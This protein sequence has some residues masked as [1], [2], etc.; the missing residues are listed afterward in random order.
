ME[1][2]RCT[3]ASPIPVFVKIFLYT[4][5][6]LSCEITYLRMACGYIHDRTQG[7]EM[8]I[9][10]QIRTMKIHWVRRP[11][12]ANVSVIG[13]HHRSNALSDWLQWLAPFV[14]AEYTSLSS[15]CRSSTDTSAFTLGFLLRCCTVQSW[16]AKQLHGLLALTR[17]KGG[18]CERYW[19]ECTI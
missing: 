1:D 9:Q 7:S 3:A 18:I 5:W 14:D 11:M 19:H 2:I 17:A 10:K 15:V 13:L 6:L 8:I 12:A 4:D 16:K